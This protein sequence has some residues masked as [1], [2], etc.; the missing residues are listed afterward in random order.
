MIKKYLKDIAFI[1]AF[2]V[3]YKSL[4]R[5]YGFTPKVL[6]NLIVFLKEYT[7]YKRIND[8]SNFYLGDECL[9][10]C[11]TDRTEITPLEPTYFFQDTWAARKIF[12]LKPD[13]H[14]DVGSSAKTI[15]IISQFVP[16]TMIDIRPIQLKLDNLFFVK[17]SVLALP[18]DDGSIDSLSSLCVIEHIG[19]GRYGDPIDPWGS[20]KSIKE[21][22]RVLKRGGVLLFSVPIDK[23]NK[24]Y[25]NAHRAFTRDYIIKLFDEFEILEERYQHGNFLY[26]SYDP[27]KGFGTGL[28]LLRKII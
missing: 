14:Y 1:R 9:Y 22:K 25:F 16:V 24:V 27:I 20:E 23:E 7:F 6:S 17:G 11:L 3:M 13:H 21:L 28:F 10:P 8:N 4:T 12:E 19:L 26:D 18:F 2:Y 15:G 5:Q